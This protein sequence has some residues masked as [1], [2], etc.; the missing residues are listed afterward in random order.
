MLAKEIVPTIRHKGRI[1]G[2]AI[3][4]AGATNFRPD[5]GTFKV[6]GGGE[7]GIALEVFGPSLFIGTFEQHG[8]LDVLVAYSATALSDDDANDLADRAVAALTAAAEPA[9]AALED[10]QQKP[11]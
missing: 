5:S 10:R 6:E 3:T 8:T 7:G 1:D 9:R 4:T 2:I 11:A